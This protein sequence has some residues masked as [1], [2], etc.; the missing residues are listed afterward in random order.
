MVSGIYKS[1]GGCGHSVERAIPLGYEFP[2][3][4]HCYEPV[5]WTL[6]RATDMK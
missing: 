6:V 1:S 2:Q 3:C 4:S 5:T